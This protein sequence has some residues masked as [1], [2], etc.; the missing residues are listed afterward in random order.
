MQILTNELEI[1]LQTSCYILHIVLIEFS[2][3]FFF[4]LR[5]HYPPAK[6]LIYDTDTVEVLSFIPRH[7]KKIKIK[8][9]SN[10]E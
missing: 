7:L 2:M 8:Q 1:K 5:H 3:L 4:F 6:C 9:A 10:Q